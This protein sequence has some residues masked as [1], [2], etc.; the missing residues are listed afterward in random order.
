MLSIYSLFKT[1]TNMSSVRVQFILFIQMILGLTS[2]LV[3]L[4][5]GRKE[6]V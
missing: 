3:A 6:K 4:N 1:K 2:F 5:Q